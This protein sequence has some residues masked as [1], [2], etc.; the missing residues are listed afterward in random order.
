VSAVLT[1]RGAS[2]NDGGVCDANDIVGST[3]RGADGGGGEGTADAC[4]S[5]CPA[6]KY[7]PALCAVRTAV[8]SVRNSNGGG[9]EDG[10]AR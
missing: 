9:G 6:S 4:L 10:C 1:V 3:F 5:P 7:T 8:P 2:D